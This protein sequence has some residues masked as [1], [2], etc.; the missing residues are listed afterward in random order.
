[1]FAFPPFNKS[2]KY[3]HKPLLGV[4]LYV[5]YYLIYSH[6]VY[7]CTLY[8]LK[9]STC[10]DLSTSYPLL[11]TN[12]SPKIGTQNP[13]RFWWFSVIMEWGGV[14]Q[15]GGKIRLVG[16]EGEALLIVGEHD[17]M[18][19]GVP[20]ALPPDIVEDCLVSD[21]GT[22]MALCFLANMNTQ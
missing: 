2:P 8:V 19:H 12:I 9:T 7:S 18:L 11:P 10:N 20:L 6:Y 3:S 4:K 21:T 17:G 16:E 15:N 5:S 1:M 13:F 14:G 22:G